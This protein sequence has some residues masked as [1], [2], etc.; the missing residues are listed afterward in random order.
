M[1]GASLTF[2][3]VACA[4]LG[5]ASCRSGESWALQARGGAYVDGTGRL[6]VAVLATLRDAD[7]A[8]P[9]DAWTGS[10]TGPA[11]PIGG[12]AYAAPGAGS[13]SSA[14]WPEEPSFEGGYKLDLGAADG[15]GSSA[16]FDVGSGTGI[17]PARPDPAEGG[18]SIAWGAVPGAASY[19]CRV[20]DGAQLALRALGRAPACDLAALPE[21]AYTASVLAYSADLVAV[22][23]SASQRPALPDRFDVSEARLAFTRGGAAPAPAVLRVA[24]GAFDDGTS[25]PTRGLAVWT[26]I[27]N[28]D[29]TP[30][31][32]PWTI[33]VVGPGLATSAPLRFTYPANFSRL[34]VWVAEVPAVSGSYGAVA[35][36]SAGSVAGPFGVGALPTIGAPTGIAAGAGAQGSGWV[37]WTAV[38]GAASYLVTA[39]HRVTQRYASA[40]WVAGLGASFPADTFV[41]G[42]T[43]DVFVAASDADVVGGGPPA[44]FAITENTYQPVGFVAR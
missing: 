41:A 30:T 39:R 43:Y 16:A 40:Q 8:G 2:I 3:V 12:T 17:A 36:S 26:S 29:G 10:L 28:A 20:Y 19:E 9:A 5:L 14:W 37:T 21:G 25:S 44:P 32:V 24:G 27:L 11:G 31:T 18:A 7:G 4:A 1:R 22:A 38:P 35:R 23:S 13:W 42:E 6:G 34:V 33:E 15:S